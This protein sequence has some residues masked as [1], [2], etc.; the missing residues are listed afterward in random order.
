[1]YTAPLLLEDPKV[2]YGEGGDLLSRSRWE[3]GF[4]SGMTVGVFSDRPGRGGQGWLPVQVV[5]LI[6]GKGVQP[7]QTSTSIGRRR[8]RVESLPPPQGCASGMRSDRADA[9]L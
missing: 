6:L 4:A 1:M 9:A 7:A 3:V 5:L 8:S 2:Y